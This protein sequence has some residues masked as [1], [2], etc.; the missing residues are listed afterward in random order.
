MGRVFR[1]RKTEGW[2]AYK[3]AATESD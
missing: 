1:T 3:N 2:N